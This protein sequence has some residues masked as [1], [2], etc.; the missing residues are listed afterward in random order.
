MTEKGDQQ[1]LKSSPQKAANIL[2]TLEINLRHTT[3]QET[4]LQNLLN[5]R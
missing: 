1:I 5:F 4:Y 2:D 3:N